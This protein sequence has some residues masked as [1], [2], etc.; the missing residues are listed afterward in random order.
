MA[1]RPLSGGEPARLKGCSGSKA[2]DHVA[3]LGDQDGLLLPS[4]RDCLAALQLSG[5]ASERD[6]LSC[7]SPK[8][9]W[10]TPAAG[11]GDS[12]REP[13]G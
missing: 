3:E 12:P 8:Q 10:S 4:R 13:S 2:P 9:S 6:G 11:V 7:S 1:Q 5:Y